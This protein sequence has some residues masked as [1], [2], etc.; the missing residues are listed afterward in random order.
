MRLFKVL[1]VDT[2][3]NVYVQFLR[4]GFVAGVSLMVDFGGLIILKEYAHIHYLI[5][6]TISFV[7]GLLTNYFLSSLWVFE[8]SKMSSKKREF[9][10]FAAI[11]L[12]GLAL[13]DFL[14]WFFTD[15]FG[16][17]YMLSKVIATI[18]VYFWNFGARKKI[19]F[20]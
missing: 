17:Y 7:A 3:K 10:I 19:L 14:L 20:N 15:F 1:F 16:L 6:A 2:T 13:T 12:V 18:L 9:L 4:Y 8:S 5:A 11:G